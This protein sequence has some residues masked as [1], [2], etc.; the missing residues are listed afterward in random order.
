MLEIQTTLLI[1]MYQGD[2]FKNPKIFSLIGHG[3]VRRKPIADDGK[4]FRGQKSE[5]DPFSQRPHSSGITRTP[6]GFGSRRRGG[7]SIDQTTEIIPDLPE[8]P[9]RIQAPKN[10]ARATVKPFPLV[11]DIE[12]DTF[13]S[14]SPLAQSTLEF[15]L[16]PLLKMVEGL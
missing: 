4:S 15:V 7:M 6:T 3:N 11:P 9:S 12:F 10:D 8:L 14:S 2:N 5:D 1:S 16:N 13:L